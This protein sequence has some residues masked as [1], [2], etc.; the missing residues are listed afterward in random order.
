MP[1]FF[2]QIVRHFHLSYISMLRDFDGSS[3]SRSAYFQS[4]RCLTLFLTILKSGSVKTTLLADW[5]RQVQTHKSVSRNFGAVCL[6]PPFTTHKHVSPSGQTAENESLSNLQD[7]SICH[8]NSRT[9]TFIDCVPVSQVP[10]RQH[11]RSARC[12]QLSVQRVRR[13]T[14][15]T[16][17]FSVAGPT[18]WNSL[19]YHLQD[20]A[21]DSEQF[22]R[23]LKTLYLIAGHSKALEVFT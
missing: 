10:G 19:P 18:V 5:S 6:C 7:S 17:A 4:L 2:V 23:D 22:R 3:I 21:A 8:R 16:R 15:G 12:H 11:L 9:Y 1:L 13:S 20:L 14:F